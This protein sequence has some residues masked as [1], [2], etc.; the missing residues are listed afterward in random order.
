MSD[1]VLDIVGVNEVYAYAEDDPIS[2]G[3]TI[4]LSRHPLTSRQLKERLDSGEIDDLFVVPS[5]LNGND[6]SYTRSNVRSFLRD[7]GK[8]PGVHATTDDGVAIRASVDDLRIV[9]AISGLQD[10]PLYDESDHNELEMDL[11]LDAIETWAA[12]DL[13]RAIRKRTTMGVAVGEMSEAQAEAVDSVID[14]LKDAG[15]FNEQFEAL[16]EA[17]GV[18]WNGDEIDVDRIVRGIQL[19]D[20]IDVRL[21]EGDRLGWIGA[22]MARTES[23]MRELFG[24]EDGAMSSE[25]VRDMLDVIWLYEGIQPESVLGPFDEPSLLGRLAQDGLDLREAQ[26]IASFLASMTPEAIA[27]YERLAN[28]LVGLTDVY[29]AVNAVR[30]GGAGEDPEEFLELAPIAIKLMT[31]ANA[32]EAEAT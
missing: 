20:L 16:R 28:R 21:P 17:A 30:E 4:D 31:E 19:I 18:E 9:D 6:D 13:R 14:D 15:A 8:V 27:Q 2:D 1:R 10:Y 26:R 3:D 32:E 25:Q 11:R 29:R 7:F 5:G 24:V 23:K 22:A 12:S